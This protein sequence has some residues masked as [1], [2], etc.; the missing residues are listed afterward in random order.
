MDESHIEVLEGS[1]A[2]RV[3]YFIDSPSIAINL[4]ATRGEV[5]AGD[6]KVLEVMICDIVDLE[7]SRHN[8]AVRRPFV[9]KFDG[10]HHRL[11]L[12]FDSGM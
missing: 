12:R 10:I 1:L 11:L 4:S 3:D 5:I 9:I 6:L 7:V 8:H 2:V